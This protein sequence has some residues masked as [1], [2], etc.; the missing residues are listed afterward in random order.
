MNGVLMMQVKNNLLRALVVFIL[1]MLLVFYRVE[2]Q[3][4]I[5]GRNISII[6]ENKINQIISEYEADTKNQEE[7]EE[8]D[9][10]VEENR[11]KDIEA[12][13]K[14][15][16]GEVDCILEIS[17]IGLKQPVI[18]GDVEYNLEKYFLVTA[19]KEMIL[20]T[21]NYVILGHNVYTAYV[22]FNKLKDVEVGDQVILCKDNLVFFY[23]VAEKYYEYADNS[24][25][26]LSK[27]EDKILT[28]LTCKT[29]RRVARTEYL[30]VKCNKIEEEE[31]K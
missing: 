19:S 12:N 1:L 28:L 25:Q 20:G 10:V 30:V 5:F 17:S 9:K 2:K 27:N 14:A 24:S 13:K 21:S 23:E 16:D 26:L 6:S 4:N 15:Y 29:Q 22:S 7:Q 8:Q 31:L 18:K 11:N 3:S